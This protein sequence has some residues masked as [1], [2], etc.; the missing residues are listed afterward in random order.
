MKS[1]LFRCTACL[2]AVC[3]SAGAIA[4]AQ[5]VTDEVDSGLLLRLYDVEQS[6]Q[7]LPD[8]PADIKPNEIKTIT[9]LDLSGDDF[10]PLEDGFLSEIV[11]ALHITTAGRYTFQLMSDDGSRLWIDGRVVIDHDG[12]HGAEPKTGVA[13]LSP[14]W[15]DLRILHFDAGGAE[16]LTLEWQPPGQEDFSAI[17]PERLGHDPSISQETAPGKKRVLLALRRGRPGDGAPVAGVH[18]AFEQSI[19]ASEMFGMQALPPCER[20]A[21]RAGAIGDP[22][23]LP[24]FLPL[25]DSTVVLEVADARILDA[26]HPLGPP[27][28][29][30]HADQLDPCLTPRIAAV[31]GH[32]E[33]FRVVP[34]GVGKALQGTAF[35]FAAG[36]PGEIMGITGA[37]PQ[38]LVLSLNVPPSSDY[39]DGRAQAYLRPGDG[40][41][42]EMRNVRAMSNGL[43]IE[44]TQPLDPRVGWEAESYYIEQLPFSLDKAQP[45]R[46]DGVEYPVKSASVSPDRQRVFLETNDLKPNH[47][48]YLRLLPP[49]LSDKGE[50]PWSTE[51]WLTLH[52]VPA[53]QPGE[54]RRPPPGE[55]QN[56]LTA[57]ERA[58]GWRLLF[59]GESTRGWRGYRQKTCPAGWVVKNG[60]LT[61]VAPAGDILTEE[62]FENFELAIEW[63]ISAGGN[64]GIFFGADESKPYPWATGP[65]FQV[66]DNAQHRDGGNTKT[67]AGSNYALHAP[68][69]DATRPVGFFNQ[70]R[71]IVNNGHVEHW[72][73]GVKIVEYELGSPDWEQR[74]ADSKFSEMP[75]YGRTRRGHIV[76]QDH[77]DRVWYRNIK[78]RELP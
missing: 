7:A 55:P 57:E 61:R 56:V 31:A 14:G 21:I 48:V 51:A 58:A 47:V 43:E 5:G 76:L 27:E 12:L 20:F 78:L 30:F 75:D 33:L 52:G 64:S 36:F 60:C 23:P 53:D 59:D 42:F 54:V 44:F 22:R 32:S 71:I 38:A 62:K 39:P 26:E 9:K 69:R 67:S 50:Q 74:V 1:L 77:G 70:A 24:I 49:C 40:A 46:R 17:P 29:A 10:A 16:R 35:R 68:S 19:V 13:L 72:L 8:L 11:G 2:L 63:R 73:N 15:H 34:D 25:L 3:L 65:E 18:P 45:P 4:F 6:L 66:L 28:D 37:I 41:T